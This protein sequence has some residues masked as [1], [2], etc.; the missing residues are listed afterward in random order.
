[1]SPAIATAADAMQRAWLRGDFSLAAPTLADDV[2]LNS[3]VLERPWSTKAVVGR[4]GPAM[5]SLFEDVELAPVIA[6]GD[7]AVVSFKARHGSIDTQLIEVLHLGEDG[8]VA[9]LT[10]Y[11]RPLPALLAVARSMQARID[12]DLLAAH[13]S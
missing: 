5:V 6:S 9:E 12:P 13:G 10:I 11:I 2:V 1:M 3:P 8:K 4:L 7:T